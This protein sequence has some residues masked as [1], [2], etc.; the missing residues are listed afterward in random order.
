MAEYRS[1]SSPDL[2]HLHLHPHLHHHFHNQDRCKDA[3]H[4]HLAK[5]E[6]IRGFLATMCWP[7]DGLPRGQ[8]DPSWKSTSA[9]S[10]V[11]LLPSSPSFQHSF[12]QGL[13]FCFQN[14]L[15]VLLV[16]PLGL[17]QRLQQQQCWLDQG[18]RK[19]AVEAYIADIEKMNA[20]RNYY[21]MQLESHPLAPAEVH[22]EES[23][24]ARC[25]A[26]PPPKSLSLAA[27]EHRPHAT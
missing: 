13:C 25:A 4:S 5:E 23:D 17:G 1:T 3:K 27:H 2:L 24:L 15:G 12:F 22:I 14:P 9:R 10:S 16:R 7:G 26:P 21:Q 18:E 19:D 11:T 8:K 6:R 20:N